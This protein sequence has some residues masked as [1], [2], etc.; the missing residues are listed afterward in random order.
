M[1]F[2]VQH[3][4]IFEA[5]YYNKKNIFSFTDVL[6]LISFLKKILRKKTFE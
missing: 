1:L 4:S 2:L 6:S 5:G 3:K